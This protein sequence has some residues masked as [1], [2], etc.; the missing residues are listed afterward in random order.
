MPALSDMPFS[1]AL[2]DTREYAIT[3]K[4]RVGGL[5]SNHIEQQGVRLFAA[6]HQE[7]LIL[8]CLSHLFRVRR[9]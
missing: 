8:L 1:R 2:R 4:A 6:R 5:T 9:Q 7:R 3:G